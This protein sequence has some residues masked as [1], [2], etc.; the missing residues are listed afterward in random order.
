MSRH[1][2]SEA[3]G[4]EILQ[5]IGVPIPRYALA[6]NITE[7]ISAADKTG[8]PLVLK[9]VSPQIIH[10]SDAGGVITGIRNTEVL[11]GAFDKIISNVKKYN[12][13]APIEGI[14]VEQQLEKGLE[15]IIGGRIDPA[16]GKVITIGMGGT[17]VE[18]I[19]DISIRVLPVSVTDINAMLHELN[20]YRLIK[21]FRNE[22]PRDK[23]AL[24]N[25]IDTIANFFIDSADIV[26]FDINPVF[27]YEQGVCA[28]DARFYTDDTPRSVIS[29][30]VRPLQKN[31]S[32]LNPLH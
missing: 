10:K 22:P 23:D 30:P 20:G 32:R 5:K 25:L 2:L 19:K 24:V 13:S 26:E 8:F 14:M 21:G 15:I 17:L 11:L 3:E 18:L 27:L 7:A 4:Y 16:F 6:T 28:V 9:V 1:L 12:P 31:C 29:E